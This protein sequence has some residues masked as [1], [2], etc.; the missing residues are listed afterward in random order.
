ML[1][2]IK[3]TPNIITQAKNILPKDYVQS[4]Q[5]KQNFNESIIARELIFLESNFLPETD[6]NGKPIFQN[7]NFWSISHKENI[8]FVWTDISPIWIDIEII[9]ERWNEIFSLHK[10]EEYNLIGKKDFHNFYVLWTLKESIIKLNLAWID[11]L[12]N[13]II[14]K[15]E[16]KKTII[17]WIKFDFII[18]WNFHNK[19][20]IGYS[21]FENNL[22]WSISSFS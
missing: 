12:E 9:K 5:N 18:L 3:V 13:I 11:D 16:Y 1:K 17:D 7:N 8:V 4:L 15:I 20:Y 19:N 6:L 10:E 21:G 22:V 2:I 14:N